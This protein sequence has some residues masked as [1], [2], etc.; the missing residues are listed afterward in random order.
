MTD[1]S[2]LKKIMQEYNILKRAR[3]QNIV[4]L[5]ESFDTDSHT[6]YVMEVC[7][8]GDLLTYVRR[9]RKLKEDLAKHVFCQLIRGLMYVHSKRVLHRDIKLDNILLTSEGD[10]KICDFG[11]SKLV[12]NKNQTQHEQCGTPAYIAPEVFKGKGYKGFQSDVWSAG[13][14]LYAMLY[15][16]VPF[17][18]TNMGELQQQIINVQCS[19][20]QPGDISDGAMS[21]LKRILEADPN[22][23]LTPQQILLDPWMQLTEL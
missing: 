7:G 14:V 15:G 23:R 2:S 18:A 19:W 1:E 11:V 10:V 8:G 3:H 13:V 17:K 6:V 22:K 12:Q 16:T 21:I 20:G 4:R 5:Y 9:R